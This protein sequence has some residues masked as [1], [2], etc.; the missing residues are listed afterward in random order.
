MSDRI[1]V[2][3]DGRV[4]QVATPVEL[5]EQPATLVR[6]RL[7][8]HLQPARVATRRAAS[9][10]QPAGVRASGPRSCACVRGRRA[11]RRP[12]RSRRPGGCA[13]SSTSAPS[14]HAI[15]ELDAGAD[16]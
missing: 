6:R 7:R 16:A 2:F 9:A 11:G 15:V 4:E 14:T 1:A 8:R 3:N 5:Y 13:R 10:R 12:T